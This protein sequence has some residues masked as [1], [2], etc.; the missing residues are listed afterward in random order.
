MPSVGMRRTT[1]V[2]G[3]RVLRSG[4]RL[5]SAG[6]V[7]AKHMRAADGDEWAE[8]LDNSGDG[9]DASLCKENGW[10]D[11][12]FKHEEMDVDEKIGE[13]ISGKSAPKGS[14]NSNCV[15]R[16]R[17]GSVYQRKRKTTD[18]KSPE[19]SGPCEKKRALGNRRYGNQFTRKQWRKKTEESPV[20]E[21][22][23]SNA[24]LV[25]RAVLQRRKC[26]VLAASVECSYSSSCWFARFLNL[27]LRYMRKTR[28]TVP[29]LLA[30]MFSEPLAQVFSSHGIHFLQDSQSIKSSGSCKIFGSKSSIPL[31]TV[32]FSA[33]PSC[34]MYLHSSMLLRYLCLPYTLVNHSM[35]IDTKDDGMELDEVP[36]S[37]IPSERDLCGSKTIASGNDNSGKRR[38]LQSTV[39]AP[40]LASRTVQSRNGVNSRSIQKRR[41]SLRSRRKRNPSLL[42]MR[43]AD[44]AL[45]SD[46]FSFRRDG[47]PLSPV[48]SVR[49]LR[50]SSYRSSTANIKEVNS[51]LA[52]LTQ[53]I[54][55]ACCSANILVIESDKCHREEGATIT[56]ETSTTKQ[57]YLA[58][59]RE[60]IMR[61][62]LM[63]QKIMRPSSCNR[64]THDIIWT[65]DN[66]S[67]KLEFP[68]RQ[69]WFIFKELYREC[70]GRNVQASTNKTTIPVPGVQEVFG[71]SGV[72][73]IIFVRP[74]S[75]IRFKNDEVSRALAKRTANYD[76]DS[77][78]EEWLNKFN[79]QSSAENELNEHVSEENFELI[80]DAF[81]K[82]FYCSPDDFP[83]EKAADK[84]CLGLERREV[85]EAVY[86]YWM[87]KRRQRRTALVKIFQCY[88][89]RRP[90]LNPNSVLRKKRSF[91][92]QASQSRKGKQRTFLQE[93]NLILK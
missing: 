62:S 48:T 66:N 77:E 60:G 72:H 90:R 17:W 71:Y 89:P 80:I 70:S 76:M 36:L 55:S 91:K 82:A 5:W 40:K 74:D 87:R 37:C 19:L 43:R 85:I 24:D 16:R 63:A 31:F 28:V 92:R 12:G 41:S 68:N 22:S 10:H 9:G 15:N 64:V 35:V 61:Y 30:F 20:A 13:P 11:T 29:Q 86:S 58:V 81:E 50:S 32:D 34:F 25:G 84:L 1:R 93:K 42:G 59:K 69:D 46:I 21:T 79:M 73:S 56:L 49:E 52:G 26:R 14:V 45:L 4:R 65:E 6:A 3:A 18:T 44:G 83:D 67:W 27:V 78:D 53:D 54:D 57:W 7:E 39:G 2:F 88:Q 75:Y 23:Y 38:V 51:T 33:V 8:I 47:I